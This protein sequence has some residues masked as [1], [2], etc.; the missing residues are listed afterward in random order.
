MDVPGDP[1]MGRHGVE[2]LFGGVLGMAGH[3]AQ[4]EIAGKLRQLG[5]EIGKV[6]ARIQV[7]AV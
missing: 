5:Q 2:E 6:H 4:Q 3:E 7:P 1:G